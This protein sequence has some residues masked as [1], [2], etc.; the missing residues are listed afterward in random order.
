M[1][2][3]SCCSS[4]IVEINKLDRFLQGKTST[5]SNLSCQYFDVMHRSSSTIS[6]ILRLHD[7][8]IEI[9]VERSLSVKNSRSPN[10]N[11][12]NIVLNLGIINLFFTTFLFCVFVWSHLF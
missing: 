7:I 11:Y 12:Y 6:T 9:D 5:S 8:E 4:K 1:M 10:N 2:Y 3:S